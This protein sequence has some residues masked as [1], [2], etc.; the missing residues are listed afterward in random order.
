[1]KNFSIAL[2]N[3]FHLVSSISLQPNVFRGS[4]FQ[5]YGFKNSGHINYWGIHLWEFIDAPCILCVSFIFTYS[6]LIF[7]MF[8]VLSR[9]P[10]RG[11]GKILPLIWEAGG[12]QPSQLAL[13][14]KPRFHFSIAYNSVTEHPGPIKLYTF[15]AKK[16]SICIFTSSTRLQKFQASTPFPSEKN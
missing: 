2:I 15:L 14:L 4:I 1:M 16:S 8:F 11:D 13:F 9:G 3:F 7:L 12:S 5:L 10:S 6:S